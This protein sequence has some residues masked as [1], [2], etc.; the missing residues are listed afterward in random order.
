MVG[1]NVAELVTLMLV[2]NIV[3]ICEFI[4]V[5]NNVEEEFKL[6]TE[7][8]MIVGDNVELAESM[9][10]GDGNGEFLGNAVELETL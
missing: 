1:D 8:E 3:S 9:L 5:G 6:D 10:V 7:D 4:T 2:G